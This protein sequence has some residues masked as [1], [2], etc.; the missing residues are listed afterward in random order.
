[1]SV[2]LFELD[3]LTRSTLV[4]VL[5]IIRLLALSVTTNR[6]SGPMDIGVN[7]YG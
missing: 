6:A 3:F 7:H 1:M 2:C 4:P 5:P